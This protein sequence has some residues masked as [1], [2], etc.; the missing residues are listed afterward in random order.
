VS[1]QA[2]R[3]AD[4]LEMCLVAGIS[5]ELAFLAGFVFP[6]FRHPFALVTIGVVAGLASFRPDVRAAVSEHKRFA[7]ALAVAVGIL[8]V[9]SLVSPSF[10][11][12][13]LP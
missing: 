2:N 6:A 4:V 11:G 5:M 1:E 7:I 13:L 10:I 12:M 3:A 8:L 9:V